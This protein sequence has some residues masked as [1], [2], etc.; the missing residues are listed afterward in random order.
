MQLYYEG[1][2]NLLGRLSWRSF[3]CMGMGNVKDIYVSMGAVVAGRRPRRN[4]CIGGLL[5]K[6]TEPVCV[7]E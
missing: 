4:S 7:K 6:H 1:N 5:N 3:V 2:A